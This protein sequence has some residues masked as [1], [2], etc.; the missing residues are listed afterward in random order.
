MEG[1]AP[2]LSGQKTLRPMIVGPPKIYVYGAIIITG[3]HSVLVIVH[4]KNGL[5]EK[6]VVP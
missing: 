2:W 3:E 6:L 5:L 4:L 1:G